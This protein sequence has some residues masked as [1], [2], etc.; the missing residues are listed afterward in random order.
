MRSRRLWT[1]AAV[2]ALGGGF[3][4]GVGTAGYFDQAQGGRIQRIEWQAGD[5]LGTPVEER[6][7][8]PEERDRRNQLL[9]ENMRYVSMEREVRF[10][11]GD[12]TG[13]AGI[14]N[15]G[16]SQLSCRVE[17]IRDGTGEILY[18]SELI[19]PGF[20]IEEIQLNTKLRKGFYPCTALWGFYEKETDVAI[21]STAGKVVVCVE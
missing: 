3:F 4:A 21:G 12:G 11:S 18:R 15:G 1:A 17:L 2:L 6:R 19:D 7:E 16:E 20:Y 8:D 5:V 10:A 14:V 9:A 13:Y